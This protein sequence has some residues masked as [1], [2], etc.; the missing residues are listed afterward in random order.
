MTCRNVLRHRWMHNMYWLALLSLVAASCAPVAQPTPA[1]IPTSPAPAPTAPAAAPTQARPA[2]TPAGGAP[3]APTPTAR[4][5]VPTPAPAA[6][7][8]R[9]GVLKMV[10]PSEEAH[11]DPHRS[12]GTIGFWDYLASYVVNFNIND[13]LPIPEL[14]EKWE[15]KDPRTLVLTIRKGVKFHNLAPVNGR[16]LTAQDIVWN[17]ERIRR[18]GAQYIW[19]SNFEPVETFTAPDKYTVQVKTK[20][21]FA[22]ILTYL[23][24]GPGAIQLMLAPEVEEKLGGEDAYKS[25][26]NA[27]ATG[28]FMIK[29]YTRDVGAEAVRNPDYWDAG[30]PYLDGVQ[31]FIVPDSATM[32]AAFRTAKVDSIISYAAAFDIVAK[33]DLERT[34]P[35]LKLTAAPDPYPLALVPNVNRKPFDDI[36]IRKAMF[37]AL[38]RQEM[39]KVNIGGGGH[40]SGPMSPRLFPG[41]TW[42]EEELLKREGFRPKDTPDGQKDITEAQRLMRE[43]GY[44]PD[45]PL[46][47]EAEGTQVFAYINLTPTEIAKSELRKV[48]IEMSIKLMERTQ[49]FDSDASGDFLLRA[50]G[51]S[52]PLEPDAQLYTRHH[53]GAGRNFQK[54]SDPELD[55]LLDAQRQELDITKRKQIMMQ[56]QEKLWSLYPQM[57]LHTRDTYLPNQSW[58]VVQPSVYRRWGDTASVWLNR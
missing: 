40:L 15:F 6:Q 25:L 41:W 9:G 13:G 53:T 54:L 45:K 14:A 18:P 58:V 3:A 21:P 12:P 5:A 47:V 27:R 48:Y 44:G 2:A 26:T 30:K 33:R 36:R 16:E 43:A 38:D 1:P 57:W 28:P 56:I 19:K 37:L 4:P 34:T 20:Y 46:V 23:K 50:R 51:Y 39:L 29:S 31:M 24:G 17:L 52:A 49:W 55:K 10:A 7:I 11:S 22:P 35:N 42:T 32:I 8:K